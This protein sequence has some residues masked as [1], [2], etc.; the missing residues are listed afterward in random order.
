MVSIRLEAVLTSATLAA[1]MVL[2]CAEPV[3]DVDRTQPN[4]LPKSLFQGE[5]YFARTVVDVPYEAA[6]TF[7]GDR[8]EYTFGEDFPAIKI[9][10]R[11]EEDRLYACRADEVIVGS[12][13]EGQAEG[14]EKDPQKAEARRANDAEGE[15]FRKFPCDHPVAAFAIQSHFDI[16]RDYNAATGEQSNVISENTVDRAWHERDFIRVDWT[17]LGV[18]DTNFNLYAQSDLGWVGNIEAPYYVQEEAGDCRV[19]LADGR[20]DYSTCEEGFVPP[21]IDLETGRNIMLTQ[22]MTLV[23]EDGYGGGPINTCFRTSLFGAGPA[24][25]LSEIGMRYSFTRVPERAPEAE[26]E[27]KYYPDTSFERFGVWRVKK[28]TY[29]DGRGE[30]DFK[31]YRATRFHMWERTQSCADGVCTALPLTHEARGLK[32]IVYYL[33]R[34][35]P[36][37]LKPMAFQVAKEWNDAFQGIVTDVDLTT[38]CEVVCNGSTPAEQCGPQDTWS[39]TGTCAFELRENDGQQFL[40]DLRY[41][42]IAYIE[43][44][45]QGQPCGVGGPANDPET[46]ELVNAVTY[47]YGAGCFDYLTTRMGDM[48]DILCAQHL[49]DGDPLPKSCGT[50]DE[51]QYLRGL[52]VLEIMQAQGYV[53]APRTPIRN[54]TGAAYDYTQS[55]DLE[56]RMAE[57]KNR[58][59]D[60]KHQRGRL[61][62]R[63]ERLKEAGLDRALVPDELARELSGGRASTGAE[64]TDA[65][66]DWLNP[67]DLHYSGMAVREREKLK[68]AAKALEPAEYLFDDN[69][70][71]HFVNQHADLD[72]DQLMQLLREQSFRA[73]TLHE[74][75]HNL[76]LRHNFIASF[77]RTNFHPE[78]WRIK[79][80]TEA[81]FEAEFGRPAPALQPFR[82][83]DETDQEFLARYNQWQADRE[84]LRRM[85]E[86][87]GIRLHRYSSIMDYGAM[88]YSDW[89]G[90]GS[91]DRAAMRFIYADLVDRVECNGRTPEACRAQLADGSREHVKWYRGGELCSSNG[92]CP[93]AGDGQSCR[94]DAELGV[95][96]CSNWDD[97]ERVAAR[98]NPRQMFCSDDRVG[99]QP[100][101]NRFDEGE[102]SEEIVRNMIDQY[103]RNFIFNNF[104]RYRADFDISSYFSRIQSRYFSVI[105][106][107]MQA[108]LYKY[109]Y[110][111]GF[112]SNEGPG[113]FTDMFRAT[114]VGFDF[115]GN[116]L[117]KPESGS[118][119]L[120]E[121]TGMYE[122]QDRNLTDSTNADVVNIPLGLGKPVYSSYER[123]YFG[124]IDR[125]S[126]VGVFYDKIAALSTLTTRDWGVVTG[127]NDERFQLNFYDFF[128][129]AF[130]KV[131]GSFASGDFGDV[132][133]HYDSDL[134]MLSQRVYWDGTF[135]D[136]EREFDPEDE[137]LPGAMVEPGGSTQLYVYALIYGM[138]DTPYFN[139]LTFTHSMRV[140]EEG[141]FTGFDV[142]AANPDDILRCTSP[143]TQRTFVAARTA[144]VPSIAW[145]AVEHCNQL[146]TQ[147]NEMMQQLESGELPVGVT[148]GRLETALDRLEY[149]LQLQEDQISNMIFVTDL[150]GLGAL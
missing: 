115:L 120:N 95:G 105:G 86:D 38:S 81:A 100:F 66:L 35:F 104:R 9:R 65:E 119:Q 16:L 101:C 110:E 37:D 44:P 134:G 41:N 137:D 57:M 59:T 138:I 96:V 73:V 23:P 52:R 84:V 75:G 76:G 107:Q 150:V 106:D 85:Q 5:W 114:V 103:E 10:W 108:L 28:N 88:Y 80:E 22:R 147:R 129:G 139:D 123:G 27:V 33:N 109:F 63:R 60:L 116:V 111:P 64:L 61:H 121:F 77:D 15:D 142:D 125:L 45:G 50:I 69:G 55:P 72:R 126:Y 145:Q 99:D 89:Q 26:F 14:D 21:I 56:S 29:E 24:C 94:Q 12:N 127:A 141:G 128:P 67:I 42:Y 143:L 90:L 113:G 2:G 122:H 140:F 1:V 4:A 20:V 131:L 136:A 40:G 25:T 112:R 149:R 79:Q 82:D 58:M 51:N 30:T 53:Q 78:Y 62:L 70:L 124:E 19:R 93:H 98:F 54:I 18:S 71:W 74:L 7:V 46:G 87:A 117:M 11:I 39:M 3:D 83:D 13:S 102:S 91:Y 135:F 43:D 49:R 68:Y 146:V 47:V 133:Q 8:Q 34:A 48:I 6:G 148:R 118:Y 31:Q 36:S 97:D 32:P 130:I 17:D 144:N 92:D 132:A